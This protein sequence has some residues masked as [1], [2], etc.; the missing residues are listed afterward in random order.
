MA[1]AGLKS[2][3]PVIQKHRGAG[4][5]A[6]CEV[7]GRM[8]N[9]LDTATAVFLEFGYE[10]ANVSEIAR[11]AGASKRTIYSRYPTKAELFVAVVT[12]KTLEL[13]V[14]YA[15]TLVPRGSLKTVLEGYGVRLLHGMWNPE[16]HLLY[17]VFIAASPKFPKL[18][19]RFWDVG[20]KRSMAMLW[21]YLAEHPEFKGKHPEHA[22]EMFW[23]LCCGQSVLRALLHEEDHMSEEA[24]RLKVKEATRIFMIAYTGACGARQ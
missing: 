1:D 3:K 2:R 19:N 16:S 14:S 23:S 11:R 17:K 13:Q 18:A 12:R 20:P 24:I 4:R 10:N 5:P 22:A 15:E 8:Q 7:A 9:L 21:H 6:A